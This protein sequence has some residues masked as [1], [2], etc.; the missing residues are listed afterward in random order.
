MIN[1]IYKH[2]PGFFRQFL[3]RSYKAARSIRYNVL[4]R[5]TENALP[6]MDAYQRQ[7]KYGPQ[8]H[9][10]YAPFSSMFFSREGY[11]SPCYA[12]YSGK[13]DR[14]PEKSIHEAWFSG[15]FTHIRQAVSQCNLD[16]SCS[17][18]KVL[19]EQGNFG[20]LLINKYEPY[21]IGK[22]RYPRIMEFELSNRCN[23]ECIMCD[24]NLSSSIRQHRDQLPPE[25]DRYD[26]RFLEELRE[27][28]PHLQMAEFTGGDPFL[29]PI[30][31]DIWEMIRTLN[32]RCQIL[33]TTNGNTLS[34]RILKILETYDN[35]HFNISFDTTDRAHYQQIRI[36]ADFD[37]VMENILR[38]VDYCKKH[39]TSC[40]LLVCPMTLNSRDFA[41]LL[42][43]ANDL[44]IAVYFHTVIKPQRLSLK[45]QPPEYLEDLI[46]HLGTFTPP[47]QTAT[48]K[49]NAAN[50]QSLVR[51]IGTWLEE[52]KN[53]PSGEMPPDEVLKYL[54][55][56]LSPAAYLRM[57]RL[58]GEYLDDPDYLHLVRKLY[59]FRITDLETALQEETDEN[60]RKRIHDLLS[61][62]S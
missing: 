7:R 51:L 34:P 61:I 3:V 59:H 4:H 42:R 33:I 15:E 24:G 5:K 49:I 53:A 40:N 48:E 20:S 54:Q 35:L 21:G 11:M 26:E 31:Y 57:D 47:Q 10:C 30:Y 22:S 43:F 55:S 17:F 14:W 19:F 27:F 62:K 39:K 12:T 56:K 16:Y 50:Y 6:G 32:P 46:R 28:I 18:C 41:D 23:L 1:R 2:S 9:L 25:E 8:E 36:N 45:F 38:F 44:G 29:I 60:L 58:L 13:S 37:R 52:S